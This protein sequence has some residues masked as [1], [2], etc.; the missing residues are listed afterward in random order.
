MVVKNTKL[1]GLNFSTPSDR[2]KPTDL[3][4]TF[5]ILGD[6]VN[7]ALGSLFN[8][9]S[10]NLFNADYLGFD[11]KLFNSGLP[12]LKNVF[13]STF[14]SDDADSYS[15]FEYNATTDSYILPNPFYIVE[16]DDDTIP[17]SSNNTIVS[18]ISSGKWLI[19][20]TSSSYEV[21]RA[22]VIK[23]LFFG[24]TGSDQLI[25]DFTN[26]TSVK[27]SD[28][29]DIGKRVHYAVGTR[30]A[31]IGTGTYTGTFADTSTN[32]DCSSW[33]KLEVGSAGVGSWEI[34]EGNIVHTQSGAVT[35]D[36]FGTDTSGDDTDN[37]AD[38]QLVCTYQAS[39]TTCRAIVI[40]SGDISWSN[41][42][43]QSASNI[44]FYSDNSIPDFTSAS[45]SDIGTIR[46]TMSET[47]TETVLKA[48]PIFNITQDS[49]LTYTYEV[50]S[51]GINYISGNNAEM[52][53][54]INTG[55][56]LN[57]RV[58]VSGSF[59][60]QETIHFTETAIKYNII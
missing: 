31:S 27:S 55:T 4:D 54:L 42:G 9:I 39:P 25:L 13:Y 50:S 30:S 15:G 8:D 22:E 41:N 56:T 7:K 28:S 21:R 23:S 36:E 46:V 19:Y 53:R 24:T 47:T 10:Q 1:G 17:W 5:D 3:N 16:A 49:G 29:R 34:P 2:V 37:P 52:F 26:V 18:K 59:N 35:S 57:W 14:Q 51:D 32:L 11:S 33:S 45:L 48:I 60:G 43:L 38:C 40:C 6:V 12:N 20:S 58:T 44:D